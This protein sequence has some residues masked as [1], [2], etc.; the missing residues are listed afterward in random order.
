[1]HGRFIVR[2]GAKFRVSVPFFLYFF[3][4]LIF[5]TNFV[6][7][8][9][10]KTM[11]SIDILTGQHVTIQY[12]PA[13]LIARIG[14]FLLDYFF[15]WSYVFAVMY[16]F[17]EYIMYSI[18][19]QNYFIPLIILLLPA[20]FYH[21]LFESLSG[22]KTPGKMIV[23]IRVTNKDGSVPGIGAYFL[24]WVL[25]PVDLFPSGGLG[26]LFIVFSSS[27]QRLGDMAAGTVVVKANPS[28]LMP[29]D[30]TYY[31]FRDDYEPVFKEVSRLSEGQVDFIIR[32]LMT[33]GSNASLSGSL[34]E[35]A[36]KVKEILKIDSS[37]HGRQFL[38]TIVRDYNYY[39]ALGI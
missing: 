4:F 7:L 25:L 12:E 27:H 9:K 20:F 37:L 11:E 38:E 17:F 23:K 34:N 13:S 21:F 29:L 32:L 6:R 18:S 24:R 28:L 39:A 26:V 14:A 10:K 1:V 5:K 36:N 31:E 15:L 19:G 33:P 8:M 3:P 22:G 35:L 30:E 2:E 16:S